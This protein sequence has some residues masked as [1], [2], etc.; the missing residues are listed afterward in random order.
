MADQQPAQADGENAEQLKVDP[1]KELVIGSRRSELALIQTRHVRDLLRAEHTSLTCRIH[2]MDTQ[3]DRRL[4][5]A[6]SKI[7]DKGLFTRELEAGLLCGHIHLA[8]HSLKDMPTTLPG[9][10][11]LHR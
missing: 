8:V 7:G 11:S 10:L 4:D 3:G 9:K 5:V 6:L 2:T 1:R